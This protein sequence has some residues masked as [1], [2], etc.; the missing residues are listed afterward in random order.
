[1]KK[2]V[3]SGIIM[4]AL[5]L[6]LAA[7]NFIPPDTEP[8]V[9]NDSVV[10][11]V[12]ES[13]RRDNLAL[14]KTLDSHKV[15]MDEL[16]F[17]VEKTLNTTQ[18]GRSVA[19]SGVVITGV[20]K[21]P[22]EEQR[23]ASFSTGRSAAENSLEEPIAV[24]EFA[25]GSPEGGN[26]MFVLASDDIRVGTIL[27]VAQGSLEDAPEGFHEILQAGLHNYIA[28]TISEYE[29]ITEEEV[30]AAHEKAAYV[31][32]GEARTLSGGTLLSSD[33][34]IKKHAMLKTR[35]GQGEDVK[36][37]NDLVAA[38]GAYNNYV[39]HVYNNYLFV[40]GCGPTAIA[41]IIAFHNH[42]VPY[43]KSPALPGPF[44][45]TAYGTWT[46][47]FNLSKI[48]E[49]KTITRSSPMEERGQVGVLMYYIGHKNIGNAA[50]DNGSTGMSLN[51]ARSAFLRLGYTISNYDTKPTTT[52]GTSDNFT[53]KYNTSLATIK[54]ALDENRPI[55]FGGKAQRGS[56]KEG[57]W[58][59]IDG[60]ANMTYYIEKRDDNST[61]RMSLNN[62]LMV[63]CNLGWDGKSDGWY[64]YGIFNTDKAK[65]F[66]K[67]TDVTR[68]V[69][70]GGSNFSINT[71]ML[72]PRK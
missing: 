4:M 25:A 43:P 34:T 63:H 3:L 27:A 59:V 6:A 72:I 39:Q 30:E 19:P 65:L 16:Q 44:Y 54:N 23:F 24:Y 46:G 12:A 52:T 50:Y 31:P 32:P 11:N 35:W 8:V 61:W 60:W 2:K 49:K 71:E 9:S 58:W 62:I 55:F 21:L 36:K 42:I 69:V 29:S 20:K 53:I 40:T 17:I 70:A 18:G 67:D 56:K 37:L 13:D 22:L 66:Q 14:M 15:V 26:E 33:F 68:S 7:C 64:I 41:Q 51:E 45:N 5:G 48:R 10:S 47:S 28:E 57:H 38:N 1:M